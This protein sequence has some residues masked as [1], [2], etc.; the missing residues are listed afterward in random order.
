MPNRR[1]SRTGLCVLRIEATDSRFLVTVRTRAD[2]EQGSREQVHRTAEIEAAVQVLRDF[3]VEFT[4]GVGG[5]P[6]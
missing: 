6:T 2:S 5:Y 1:R 3:L 4:G